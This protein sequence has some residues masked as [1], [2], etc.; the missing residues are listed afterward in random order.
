MFSAVTTF[1]APPVPVHI[2]ESKREDVKKQK[3]SEKERTAKMLEQLNLDMSTASPR[4][5]VA[6]IHTSKDDDNTIRGRIRTLFTDPYSSTPAFILSYILTTSIMFSVLV[7]CMSTVEDE[8][9]KMSGVSWSKLDLIFNSI[10][11]FELFFRVTCVIEFKDTVW[12]TFSNLDVFFWI[13]VLSVVPFW[14]VQV[15]QSGFINVL[16]A[17]SMMRMLKLLRQYNHLS[18]PLAHAVVAS[19]KALAVP[20]FFLFVLVLIFSSFIYYLELEGEHEGGINN[21]ASIPHAIWSARKPRKD[22]WRA[23]RLLLSAARPTSPCKRGSALPAHMRMRLLGATNS[24]TAGASVDWG[25][26][27]ELALIGGPLLSLR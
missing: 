21:F 20:F 17:F 27:L 18:V 15:G 4:K 26:T 24:G 1:P 14:L 7:L 3:A 16:R 25:P 6:V 8:Y 22:L 13:D 5:S 12:A 23:P 9:Y 2:D 10:F 11:T 19:R